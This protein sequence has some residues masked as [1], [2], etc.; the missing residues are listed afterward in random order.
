VFILETNGLLLGMHKEF[1]ESL[2]RP[3]LRIRVSLKGTDPE[4]FERVSGARAEFF[5][6]PID[7]LVELRRLAIDSW[8]AVMSELFSKE[9][10][11]GLQKTLRAAGLTTPLE[12]ECLEPYGFV[13]QNL[14]ER[15]ITVRRGLSSF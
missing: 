4:S 14:K 8:P 2:R 12:E 1:C 9:Q 7:A 13:L 5:R 3:G 10:T 6:Y 11:L 15:R